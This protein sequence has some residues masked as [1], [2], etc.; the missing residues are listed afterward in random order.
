MSTN[1]NVKEITNC[2]ICASADLTQFLDFG[3]Q[4]LA[5]SF[6]KPE[7]LN[8]S[9]AKYPLRV[10]V[11]NK[12]RLAQLKDIVDPEIMFRDYVYFSSG[13]PASEHF[14]AY[15]RSIVD[16]FT[17]DN[18]D[19]VVDIGSNDGHF[20]SIVKELG[21][22]ILG[23]DPARNLAK[24]ANAVG[25]PTI[26]EFFSASLAEEIVAKHGYPKVVIGNN[27]VAHIGNL[28]ELVKGVKVL[29][30]KGGVFVFEAPY[31]I[32]MFVNLSFD[33][34]YHEH[35]SYF[36]VFPL[37]HLFEQYGLDIFDVQVHPI[38]GNSI[39]TFVCRK[40]D[41]QILPSVQACLDKEK[42]LGLLDGTEAYFALAE[43][44]NNLKNEVMNLLSD[45][46]QQGKSIV[47]YGA[48]AKGNTLLNYYGIGPEIL[49]YVTEELPSKIGF[50][51]PGTRI[52]VVATQV[53]RDNPSDYALMLAWNY[54]DVILKKEQKFRDNGGK[55]IM[56]IGDK[57]I[58]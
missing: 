30:E 4:P 42:A 55:F 57:R 8:E 3:L 16:G 38:Q 21:R 43:K 52:P 34:I 58:L 2:R 28:H 37:K 18:N 35:L 53:F 14:R 48:P 51:T 1:N 27:V 41:R 12:C 47:G 45:L 39:R 50:L 25:I 29:T 23:V 20:L 54:K 36:S 10:V 32:D 9:E 40:G 11:C 49:D 5:N 56:P 33:T 17:S 26:P 46:K 6:L 13:M 19:L 24:A 31:L 7:Q 15:V 44:I 22:P